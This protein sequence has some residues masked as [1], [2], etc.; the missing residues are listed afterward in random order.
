[1]VSDRRTQQHR[2][3][4]ALVKRMAENNGFRATIE[5]PLFG[6]IGRVDVSLENDTTRIAC[7]ISVTNEPAYEF[8]NLQKCLAGGFEKVVLISAD[9][10]HIARIRKLAQE[11]LVTDEVAKIEFLTPE[12]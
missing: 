5:K 3:L 10:R 12:E 2:Y 11:A 8:Q 6:G 9:A 7:E 1:P 4:Q